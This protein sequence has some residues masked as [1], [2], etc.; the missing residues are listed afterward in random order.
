MQTPTTGQLIVTARGEILGE[1]TPESRELARRVKACIN[2]CEGIATEELERGIVH[3][4]CRVLS[5]VA[6]ILETK[7]RGPRK[8]DRAA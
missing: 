1:D 6:P 8:D 2:A 4:M 7:V 3:D 5:Q